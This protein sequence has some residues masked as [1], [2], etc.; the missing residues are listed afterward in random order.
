MGGRG[1]GESVNAKNVQ[2]ICD[3]LVKCLEELYF[4]FYNPTCSAAIGNLFFPLPSLTDCEAH[5]ILFSLHVVSLIR[6]EI[7]SLSYY[8]CVK[9]LG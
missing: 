8:I 7:H 6:I 1:G 3:I 5:T 2:K 9:D 4:N